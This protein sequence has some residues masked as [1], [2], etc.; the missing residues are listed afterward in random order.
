MLIFS[1]GLNRAVSTKV[2][3]KITL[4]NAVLQQDIRN[5]VTDIAQQIDKNYWF[6]GGL[7]TVLGAGGIA[8]AEAFRRR[9][10]AATAGTAAQPAHPPKI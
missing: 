7:Y 9:A 3:P 5:L 6:F 10:P 8:T 2:V 1:W 4:D